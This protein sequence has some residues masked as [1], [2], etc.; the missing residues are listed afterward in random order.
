MDK[1]T[2][3][4]KKM[5]ETMTEPLVEAPICPCGKTMGFQGDEKTWR[6]LACNPI[7]M[8]AP[9]C[10]TQACKRPLTWVERTGCWRCLICNPITEP[11]KTEERKKKYIGVAMTEEM[12]IE[13]IKEQIGSAKKDEDEIR[14]IVRD[15]LADWHVQKPPVTATEIA[16][17]TGVGGENVH[18][19]VQVPKPET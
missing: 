14:E 16:E 3:G 5:T 9:K 10:K 12:V 17:A 18:I 4:D 7:P 2:K 19:S 1:R 13:I 11:K 15:E 8:D 6:C